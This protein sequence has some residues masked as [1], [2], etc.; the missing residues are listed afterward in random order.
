[1]EALA[2]INGNRAIGDTLAAA[3]E[4]IASLEAALAAQAKP[5]SGSAEEPKP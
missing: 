3:A 5:A 1:M 4:R 2:L